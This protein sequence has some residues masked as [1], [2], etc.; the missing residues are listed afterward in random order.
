MSDLRRGGVKNDP[1]KSDIIVPQIKDPIFQ[2]LEAP[3]AR[4]CV[5]S[6]IKHRTIEIK[7]R[8]IKEKLKSIYHLKDMA[9]TGF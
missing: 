9:A 6:R 2:I 5:K 7:V 3:L 4:K 8:K 1:E